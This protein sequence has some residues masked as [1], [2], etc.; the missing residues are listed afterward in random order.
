VLLVKLV[1][2]G[3]DFPPFFRQLDAHGTAID[4]RALMVEK[5]HFHKLFQVVG[6]VRAEIVTARAQFTGRQFL[7]ADI[8]EQQ[9]LHRIDVR[10]PPPV[11]LILDHVQKA[12]MQPLH[13]RQRLK[14]ERLNMIEAGLAI[15]RLHCPHYGLHC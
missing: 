3:A 6:D 2:D 1:N 8:E 10:P 4:P 7:V 13:E 9:G 5:A 12:A 11:E 15:R 14:I